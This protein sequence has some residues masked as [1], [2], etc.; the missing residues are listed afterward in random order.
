MNNPSTV[1][2]NKSPVQWQAHQNSNA[3]VPENTMSALEYAWS[4]GGIPELDIRQ[5]AD[6]VIIGIHDA[7]PARTA[8]VPEGME[9]KPVAE[10]TYA[11]MKD[12]DTGIRFGEAFKGEKVPALSDILEVLA[13][14]PERE[15]YLDFKQVDLEKLAELVARY[16]VGSQ[17]IFAHNDPAN[18]RTVKR[19]APEIRTM[20]W[21]SGG[22]P[23]K[24]SPRSS[25][26]PPNPV[27]RG[28]ILS[29]SI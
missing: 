2:G 14:H 1:R 27:L 20:Q 18:C 29:R 15:L 11:E 4:L 26:K 25:R 28:W 13:A 7:T 3:E 12:W 19:L 10:V 8:S 16:G 23:R 21:V 17:I 24:G 9:N 5:T 6:G 22:E